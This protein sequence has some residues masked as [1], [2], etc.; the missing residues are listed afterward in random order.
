MVS[1]P[2]PAIAQYA[3]ISSKAGESFLDASEP[4]TSTVLKI[5]T[6]LENCRL[7]RITEPPMARGSIRD[8]QAVG[9]L[10]RLRRC[11]KELIQLRG[12]VA[13]NEE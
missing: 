6:L 12:F 2:L 13:G 10:I 1:I 9:E 7:A 3:V 11:E 5:W 4:R 8:C